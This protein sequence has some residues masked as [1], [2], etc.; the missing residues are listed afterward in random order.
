MLLRRMIEHLRTQNWVAV[1]LDLVIVVVGVFIAFQVERWYEGQR[2]KSEERTHLLA[3]AEDFS[4]TRADLE[5]SIR[6]LKGVSRA[7]DTL[8]SAS[9]SGPDSFTHDEFYRQFSALTSV[10][11]FNVISRTYDSLVATGDIEALSDTELRSQLAAFFARTRDSSQ[12]RYN[13]ELRLLHDR[14]EPYID[15]NLDH[16]A[17]FLAAHPNASST[18]SLVLP[19][20]QFREVLGTREFAGVV[21]SKWHMAFDL[22]R[23]SESGLIS[24]NLGGMQARFVSEIRERLLPLFRSLRIRKTTANRAISERNGHSA[25]P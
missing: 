14:I 2:L 10:T 4:G 18:V 25:N 7:A 20:D 8:L 13:R 9:A 24:Q 6:R 19:R 1:V 15:Q 5:R 17:I 23:I 22:A 21:T 3:L 16:V 11:T 12:N